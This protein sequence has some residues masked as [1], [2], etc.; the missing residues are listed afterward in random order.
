MTDDAIE[1]I[2]EE[3]RQKEIRER[4]RAE[5]EQKGKI[6]AAILEAGRIFNDSA[7]QMEYAAQRGENS[8]EIRKA[9]VQS[10]NQEPSMRD[11]ILMRRFQ[12][13]GFKAEIRSRQTDS[14]WDEGEWPVYTYFI[15]VSW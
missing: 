13:G 6:E 1:R 4:Q 11:A 5:E 7:K 9:E 12:D 8:I 3:K 10:Y 14:Y 15:V 2:A